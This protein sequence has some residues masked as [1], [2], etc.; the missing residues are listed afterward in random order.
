MQNDIYNIMKNLKLEFYR[1]QCRNWILS[2]YIGNGAAGRTFEMLL[3][4][5]EDNDSLPDY[6]G[7]ELKTQMENSRYP[8]C[9]F[10]MALDNKPL[11]LKRL[12]NLCG[13]PDRDNPSF[14]AF[15]VTV[16][17][18]KITHVGYSFSYKLEVDYLKKVVRLLI[19]NSSLIL[20]DKSMSWSFQQLE[21]RL[22][23]KLSY[24]AFVIVK[25]W[26]LNNKI[27][28]KYMSIRFLKLKSFQLFLKL[29]ENGKI[30]V[31]FHLGYHKKGTKYGQW[32]DHGT[33]F[34]IRSD[35]L[36]ELFEEIII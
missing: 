1:I 14:K 11:E 18:N 8:I 15:R 26:N 28:F 35:D 32:Y 36:L 4:K 23:A 5:K 10:A 20:I 19:F 21:N 13:Y 12:L 34:E 22:Q 2:K 31:S 9:L 16:V 29:I 25:K 6:Y 33:T 24:L 30:L 7:I 27:Y 3:N 17:A